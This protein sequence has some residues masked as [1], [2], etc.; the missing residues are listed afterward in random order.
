MTADRNTAWH[1]LVV[2]DA[3]DNDILPFWDGLKAHNFLLYTCKK[4]GAGY[5]PMTLCTKHEDVTFGDMEWQPSSGKGN[6]FSWVV[7]RRFNN[8]AYAPEG[9]YALI[10]VE[11]DEGPIFPTRLSG[12][13]PDDLR[14]GMRVEVDYVD[15]EK[16]GLT[17]PLFKVAK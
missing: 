16:T 12:P 4:C 8:P 10:L 14:V 7:A 13:R 1:E 15:V 11:L 6:V 3:F 2:P 9:P 17:L 5:W